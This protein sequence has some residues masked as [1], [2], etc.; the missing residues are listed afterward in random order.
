MPR[1]IAFET[2]HDDE[3]AECL[4][5]TSTHLPIETL[6][7]E[8]VCSF[9]DGVNRQRRRRRTPISWEAPTVPPSLRTG[10]FILRLGG[11]EVRF[12]GH[13]RIR[14]PDRAPEW[15]EEHAVPRPGTAVWRWL[16]GVVDGPVEPEWNRANR[17]ALS[18]LRGLL[19]G[20]ACEAGEIAVV[21][22]FRGLYSTGPGGCYEFERVDAGGRSLLARTPTF[23]LE[24]RLGRRLAGPAGPVPI[25]QRLRISSGGA[26]SWYD[27]RSF[28][29]CDDIDDLPPA[30]RTL[31]SA[32]GTAFDHD[33]TPM[34]PMGDL[35]PR[36]L[37]KPPSRRAVQGAG[38]PGAEPP[39]WMN[40]PA[41]LFPSTDPLPLLDPTGEL[42]GL[43]VIAD[44]AEA[45]AV[46]IRS[47]SGT[48][49]VPGTPPQDFRDLNLRLSGWLVGVNLR[50]AGA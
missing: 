46:L 35:R 30:L 7:D 1:L 28:G 33:D 31:L 14:N 10:I 38:G 11:R 3:D 13:V 34:R 40:Y 37:L 23:G 48:V 6:F 12:R 44:P 36:F 4:R 49:F 2:I 45:A 17:S 8:G 25:V 24:I 41:L 20:P 50:G 32:R 21:N 5:I 9:E 18:Q 19:G 43:P 29:V 16:R 22:N 42:I 47:S 26:C 15:L 27:G 39:G